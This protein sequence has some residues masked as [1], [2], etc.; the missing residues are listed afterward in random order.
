MMKRSFF[1]SLAA[2]LAASLALVT[3]SH[4]EFIT[5]VSLTNNTP[6][7]VADLETTWSAGG[8]IIDVVVTTPAG[9]SSSVVGGGNTIDMNFPGF[10]SLPVGGNVAF[11]FESA[12]A[13]T[14]VTGTWSVDIGGTTFFTAVVPTRDD[15]V[16][17]TKTVVTVPEPSSMALLG[18]GMVGFFTYR[19]LFKRPATA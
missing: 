9:S 2:G 13:P 7:A 15:L 6:I 1:L 14:F 5:S 12:T 4:A 16:V 18:I 11:T 10:N 17:T 3:P 8:S 19:R